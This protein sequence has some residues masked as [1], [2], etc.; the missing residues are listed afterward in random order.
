MIRLSKSIIATMVATFIF[1]VSSPVSASAATVESLGTANFN[2]DEIVIFLENEHELKEFEY[3]LKKQNE[4]AEKKWQEALEHSATSSPILKDSFISSFASLNS[5]MSAYTSTPK[6]YSHYYKIDFEFGY[7]YGNLLTKD[8]FSGYLTLV[9]S[10]YQNS[11]GTPFFRSVDSVTFRSEYTK[12]DV[13]D[14]TYQTVMLDASRT[15]AVSASCYV[16][17]AYGS[18]NAR[19]YPVTIYKEFYASQNY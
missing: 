10:T 3:E 12:N 7:K 5:R 16:L 17:V 2:S 13:E 19:R 11:Y 4:L 1:I 15:C 9:G 18:N 6:Y 14:F 8:R